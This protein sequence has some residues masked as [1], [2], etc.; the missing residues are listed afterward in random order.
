MAKVRTIANDPRDLDDGS[1]RLLEDDGEPCFEEFVHTIGERVRRALV[2]SYGPEIGSDAASDAMRVAWERWPG[3]AVMANPA[4]YLF[5]AGQSH[6]RPGVRWSKR[7]AEFP[8]HGSIGRCDPDRTDF[9]E[10]HQ[11]LSKLKPIQ[12]SVVVLVRSHEYTYREAAEVLNI[13]ETAVTNHL[14]RGMKQ[15]RKVLGVTP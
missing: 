1:I 10:V 14:H 11:A 5:R 4:G 9:D 7:R 12:R 13:S 8:R 2:A 15:L 6:A 3:V